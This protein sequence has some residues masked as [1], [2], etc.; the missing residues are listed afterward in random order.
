MSPGD[1]AQVS[2]RSPN[3][4][5]GPATIDLAG[6]ESELLAMRTSSDGRGVSVPGAIRGP[7]SGAGLG[8]RRLRGAG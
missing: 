8:V 3:L 7:R 6:A 4:F 2:D 5:G 1:A